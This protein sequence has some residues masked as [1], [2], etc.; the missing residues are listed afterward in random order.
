[1]IDFRATLY[2]VRIPY[3]SQNGTGTKRAQLDALSLNRNEET[4][5]VTSPHTAG[6]HNCQACEA[7]R[8]KAMR[9]QFPPSALFED[10]AEEWIRLH[11]LYVC[12]DTCNDYRKCIKALKVF[13]SGMKLEDIHIGHVREYQESRKS[14]KRVN[15]ECGTV[16]RLIMHEAGLWEKRIQPWYK[17]VPTK[18]TEVGRRLTWDEEDRLKRVVEQNM[19]RKQWALAGN[20]LLAMAN[21]AFG[22]KELKYL[23]RKDVDLENRLVSLVVEAKNEERY[24][25]VPL[26]QTACDAFAYLIERWQEIGGTADEQFLLP[27]RAHV[28]GARWDFYTPMGSIKNAHKKIMKAAGIKNFR[29]YDCRHHAQ[30]KWLTNPRIS[31][32]VA[33]EMAGHISAAMRKRYCHV[34]MEQMR[35]AVDDMETPKKSAA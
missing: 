5:D 20:C 3:T 15:R 12:K 35:Q 9:G 7:A 21:I 29:I 24:R 19:H 13:F 4:G 17:P 2:T 18:K 22:F 1:L 28:A 6:H 32:Q 30:S 23:R 16:L 10:A 34:L 26:N 25:T 11:S 33:D 14:K 31:P 27:H 8:F